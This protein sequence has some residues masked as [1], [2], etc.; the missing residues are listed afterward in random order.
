MART[1]RRHQVEIASVS[2]V[3][4]GVL[5]SAH[6]ASASAFKGTGYKFEVPAGWMSRPSFSSAEVLVTGP[7]SGA[8][9]NVVVSPAQ[10]GQTLD[11]GAP[12][13]VAELRKLIGFK[14]FG[15]RFIVFA[16]ARSLADEYAYNSEQNGRLRVRQVITIRGS[17][18]IAVTCMSKESLWPRVWPA[19][20]TA[21]ASWRWTQANTRK[22][23]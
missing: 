5:L 20:K 12:E 4:L 8:N 2:T 18:V 11:K 9:M 19:F 13:T 15:H 10:P 17:R 21:L 16:G 23:A 22:R 6:V 1:T 7:V 14:S 3:L